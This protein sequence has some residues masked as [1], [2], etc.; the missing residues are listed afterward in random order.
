MFRPANDPFATANVLQERV[1]AEESRGGVTNL[2]LAPLGTKPQ[3]LGFAL[4]FATEQRGIRDQYLVP[5]H[6]RI[7]TRDHE[8]I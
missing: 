8:G 1:K 3:T 2:Y 4:Y 6:R 7:R 5:V